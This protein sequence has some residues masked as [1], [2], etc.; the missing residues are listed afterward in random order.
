MSS[1]SCANTSSARSAAS[2]SV[3]GLGFEDLLQAFGI[4]NTVAQ[5]IMA[6]Q[7]RAFETTVHPLR[8]RAETFF[9]E[10]SED[11]GLPFAPPLFSALHP[12]AQCKVMGIFG[13][14]GVHLS[15]IGHLR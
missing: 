3:V 13:Q 7:R 12:Q 5:R 10:T 14:H 15:Q 4:Q 8:Q 6:L 2:H 9:Q 11:M 1:L